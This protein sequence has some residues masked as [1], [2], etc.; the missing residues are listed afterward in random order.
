[1][2]DRLSHLF[3]FRRRG[4][5]G[6]TTNGRKVHRQVA[7]LAA[8]VLLGGC[9]GSGS[10]V[11]PVLEDGVAAIRETH[12]YEALRAKLRRVIARLRATNDGQARRLALSGFE[13]TL[14][15]VQSRIDFV[16][17]D[18]GNIDAATRDA[19]RADAG[20]RE[21]ARLLRAAG[22]LLDVRVGSLSGY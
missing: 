2:H 17:N 21:G 9:G 4:S 18:R 3:S 15:G 5:Y 7:A 13:A 14:R 10:P 20:L 22:R 19:R 12:D 8:L 1:M 11:K 6:K 16:E